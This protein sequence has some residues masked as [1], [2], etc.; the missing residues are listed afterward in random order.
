MKRRT[1]VQSSS[2]IGISL[3]LPFYA[4]KEVT[5]S[6]NSTSADF[7]QLAFSLLKE[8]CDG[9]LNVQI[10]QPENAAI[11]G[12]LECPACDRIHGRCMDA[13]FPFM[14][15]AHQTGEQ[16][17]LD[18]AIEV[19]D[20]AD[21]VSMPDGS[22]T[23]VPN[24]KSWRGIT[25]FGA[26]AL[27]EALHYHGA[28]LP[29][30][31][32]EKWKARL[33]RAGDYL[34]KNFNLTFTNINY[35][36]TAIYALHL[37]G[38]VLDNPTYLE[39]SKEL[40]SGVKNWFTEPN[41]LLFGEGKPSDK[42]SAKG[43]VAVDLGY[44]VEESLNGVVQY[45]L[46]EKDEELLTLLEQSLTGHLHFMLPDGGWDNSW[47]TRQYKWSYWGSRTTD[48]CQIAYGLMH[49]RN[50]AFGTAAYL[51][52]ELL[53]GCTLDGLL[54]GGLH[55]K[56]HGIKPCVHHTFAHA[57]P[58]ATLLNHKAEIAKI[59]K[60]VAIPRLEAQGV[61]VFPELDVWTVAQGDFR[62]TVSSYDFIYKEK[63]QQGSGG[64]LCLLYHLK[65]GP[66][67]TASMAKYLMIEKYNQQ[68]NPNGEDFALT[69]RLETYED[70]VWFTNLYDLKAKVVVAETAQNSYFKIQA[71][72]VNEARELLGSESASYH[73][74]YL[75]DKEKVEI[76]A[77]KINDAPFKAPVAM[78]LPIISP[79]G[80]K[81]QQ[82]NPNQITIQKP[83]GVVTIKSNVPLQIKK[84]ARERVFNMVP[85]VEAIPIFANFTKDIKEITCTISIQ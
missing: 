51:S 20:W 83:A 50:P 39:R 3:C 67:F 26:I 82:I 34:Y 72:L 45:A 64:S 74:A 71:Q 65:V 41:K 31:I 16:K 19:M 14:Y 33:A 17:Y 9:M 60:K 12:A 4:C 18:A 49:H 10:S 36:F 61:K 66:I 44:N 52:T 25:V 77:R 29:K 63:A 11:H 48:G 2:A 37:L 35:G 81:V 78:V 1:F 73:L 38:K 79:T 68:P 47:G 84:T 56:T 69:P 58:L 30:D 23:V 24:P 43:L 40:A 8:W 6:N 75:F 85:G 13:V 46:E 22:W 7:E 80:E 27:G 57:K 28:I 32:Y 59:N 70:G 62:A 53:Q 15:M 54:S 5:S 76:K 21:N 55:Y 42:K